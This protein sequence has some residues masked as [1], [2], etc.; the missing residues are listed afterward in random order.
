[1]NWSLRIIGFFLLSVSLV[2][3]SV[4]YAVGVLFDK[5]AICLVHEVQRAEEN[6]IVNFTGGFHLFEGGVIH[7]PHEP[8]IEVDVSE[9]LE[10]HHPWIIVVSD[11]E[12]RRDFSD[13]IDDQVV[14]IDDIAVLVRHESFTTSWSGID[15]F[16]PVHAWEAGIMA[17][18]VNHAGTQ[19][20]T[21]RREVEKIEKKCAWL[22]KLRLELEALRRVESNPIDLIRGRSLVAQDRGAAV[23]AVAQPPMRRIISRHITRRSK[24]VLLRCHHHTASIKEESV[25]QS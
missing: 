8:S 1:M 14:A 20:Y 23:R 21:W 15:E 19:Y 22:R 11:F 24:Q 9:V 18:S 3:E 4:P 16:A 7:L 2:L 25:I 12:I 13:G 17:T 5:D 10:Y 6:N